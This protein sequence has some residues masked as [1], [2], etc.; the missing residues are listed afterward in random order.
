[1]AKTISLFKGERYRSALLAKLSTGNGDKN[2][3][4]EGKN[5]WLTRD[6][7]V[8]DAYNADPHCNFTFTCNGFLNLFKLMQHTYD[9]KAY[10]LKNKTLPIFFIAGSDDPVIVSAE[11]WQN[12]QQFLREIGYENVSG[13]LYHQMRHEIHNEFGKEEVYADIIRFASGEI[14]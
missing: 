8:V 11:K 1:M 13:K 14:G 10:A 12:A 6:K 3:P 9:K 5:A 2:F 4:S 7:T